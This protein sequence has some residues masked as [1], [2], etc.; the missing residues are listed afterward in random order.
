MARHGS[1]AGHKT[2][3]CL[4]LNTHRAF[5]PGGLQVVCVAYGLMFGGIVTFKF[6]LLV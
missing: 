4:P 6:V 2:C 3:P 1:A 5:H